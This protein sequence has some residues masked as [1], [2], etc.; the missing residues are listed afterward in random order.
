V[1]PK[2][3]LDKVIREIS[4]WVLTL[5]IQPGSVILINQACYINEWQTRRAAGVAPKSRV[6][7]Q[8][9]RK[10]ATLITVRDEATSDFW[11]LAQ[12]ALWLTLLCSISETCC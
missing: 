10:L 8:V 1:C 2:A 12:G 7:R 9:K 4:V 11:Y 6:C 3:D 5:D